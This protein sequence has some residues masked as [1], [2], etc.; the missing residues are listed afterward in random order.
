MFLKKTL[1]SIK[2]ERKELTFKVFL[3]GIFFL[4]SAPALAF[5][6]ILFPIV[7]GLKKNYE[8]LKK[9]NLNYLLILA[10]FIMISK[11]IIT[12][13][14]N[15]TE[16]TNW[17]PFLNWA[18]LANWIPLFFIYFG[19]QMYVQNP[20]QRSLLAKA[21]ILGAVPVIFSCFSQYFLEWYG[22]YKLFNGF[23]V[24][25]QRSRTDINT[26]VT[27]LFNNPNYTGA[28][29]AMTWP[30]LIA[31]LSEKSKE[32]NKLKFF[33]VFV[34]SILF[35]FSIS[36][37]NSRGAFL[38]ILASIPLMFGQGVI[39]WFLPLVFIIF[40]SIIICAQPI[41]SENFRSIFCF[42]IPNNILSNFSDLSLT[43]ENLS[44]FLIWE[45]ALNLILDKPFFGWGAASFPILYFSQY[46]EWKGHPHNLFLEL[47]ISY[48][49]ITSILVFI[50]VGIIL[51][52][53]FKKIYIS[54][55]KKNYYEKAWWTST[56]IFLIH[57]S[58]DIVYFDGRI[59]IIFWILLA[60]LKGVIDHPKNLESTKSL[61]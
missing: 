8:N 51:Y 18:G 46:G 55:I 25:Y 42:L 19:A 10:G 61:S 56:I 27:G 20:K 50:F 5:L 3:L 14:W 24:W 2:F 9:D 12:S 23:I 49:L 34:L 58:F 45:K 38:A 37:I 57:H 33:I 4:A 11:S 52:K 22:P 28:W 21:F 36:L 29:L 60:G 16:I 31:Y 30:F 43:Y 40:T 47:S 48:G 6:I 13:L 7:S 44:R 53:T 15:T 17:E 35:I 32:C 39:I 41:Y 26:P 54:K 59:S 1:D